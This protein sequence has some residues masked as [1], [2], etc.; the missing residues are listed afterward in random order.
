MFYKR[1]DVKN[2]V[3]CIQVMWLARLG[4]TIVSID[5]ANLVHRLASGSHLFSAGVAF[6][7]ASAHLPHEPQPP[8][9]PSWTRNA[10]S[11]LTP[12]SPCGRRSRACEGRAG[13]SVEGEGEM[14]LDRGKHQEVEGAQEHRSPSALSQ[15]TSCPSPDAYNDALMAL[16]RWQVAAPPRFMRAGEGAHRNHLLLVCV[17]RARCRVLV[18]PAADHESHSID[19]RNA[20]DHTNRCAHV[21]L[22]V[23]I[24]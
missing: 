4:E 13:W 1:T 15:D 2:R 17:P 11:P 22:E 16:A 6:P 7:R 19:C 5:T 3:Q 23:K 8:G 10:R 12:I 14:Q 18:S 24:G 9:R 21:N 20:L